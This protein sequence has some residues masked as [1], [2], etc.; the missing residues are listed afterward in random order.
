MSITEERWKKR[1]ALSLA[2]YWDH[3]T[4]MD[5]E[6]LKRNRLRWYHHL[7]KDV[8]KAPYDYGE[9]TVVE[10][11]SGPWGIVSIIKAGKRIAVDPALEDFKE[12]FQLSEGVRYLDSKGE[13]IKLPDGVADVVFC[14]NVLNHVQNP[15]KVLSEIR[16]ILKGGGTLFFDCNLQ[17]KD[18][19]HP[20]SWTE[21]EL[22][23]MLRRHFQIRSYKRLKGERHYMVVVVAWKK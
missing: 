9:K 3:P 10:V 21:K 13:N 15:E 1:Q 2:K 22:L 8:Y 19:L 4:W 16:R 20:W 23:D 11:G 14:S 18:D 17:P 7:V 12:R 5:R 6:K